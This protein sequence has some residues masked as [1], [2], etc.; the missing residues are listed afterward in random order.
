MLTKYFSILIKK[1][2]VFFT[3]HLSIKN[4]PF[5]S[6][7]S[8]FYEIR[9]AVFEGVFTCTTYNLLVFIARKTINVDPWHIS[10][11]LSGFFVG[12]LI[13]SFV[14]QL[15]GSAKKMKYI[16]WLNPWPML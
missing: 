10:L 12:P 6:R 7:Q 9:A 11:I 13:N 14:P 1:I 2:T 3:E 8:Y 15:F 16:I 5:K 4:V